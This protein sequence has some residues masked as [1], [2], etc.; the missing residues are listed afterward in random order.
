MRTVPDVRDLPALDGELTED[1]IAREAAA[2]DF[3]HLV[4]R[5]PGGVLRPGSVG[6]IAAMMRWAGEHGWKVAARGQGHSVYGRSQVDGGLVVDM[7]RLGAVHAV[8]ADRVAVEAGATWRAVL[9]ATLAHGLTP[10]VLT[11]YLDLSVGGTLSVGGIGISTHRAGAQSDHVLELDVVTGDGRVL[12][13]SRDENADLFGA[14]LAGLGHVGIVTRAVLRLVPAPDR[15]RAYTLRYE[16]LAAL[17]A[18]QR[19][20]LRERRADHLQGGVLPDGAGGWIYQLEAAVFTAAATG[21]R[22]DDGAM[23][24]G[25]ADRR[26]AADVQDQSYLEFVSAFDGLVNLL[27]SSGHW[28]TPHPWLLTFLPGSAAE[29]IA[30]EVLEGLTPADLG[31]YGRVLFYPID[32][33]A[34]TT[35]LLR[36]PDE[37]VVFPFNLVRFPPGDPDLARG[38]VAQNRAIYERIRSLGGVL[39]P[40]SAFPLSAADWR[41]HFAG[42]W[43]LL[44]SAADRFDPRRVLDALT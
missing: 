7:S 31:P 10:P 14:V 38:L 33:G 2:D 25:L 21:A 16:D 18:D 4:H 22:P 6:D 23:L 40:V 17:A 19:R 11:N 43:E 20:V 15:V 44:R 39:Y 13:C 8:E 3:G 41:D 29:R 24:A 42:E 9:A 32:R 5:L 27:R 35:R 37:P 26:D 12:P 28:D 30:A 1:P 36:V 34:L